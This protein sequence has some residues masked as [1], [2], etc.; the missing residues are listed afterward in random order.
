MQIGLGSTMT[1]HP[2]L[3]CTCRSSKLQCNALYLNKRNAAE[4]RKKKIQTVRRHDRS[5]Y[6]YRQPEASV[7][8]QSRRQL[9]ASD[10]SH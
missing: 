7:I 10:L 9:N 6:T 3:V 8:Q 4:E 2:K 5:L 1:G